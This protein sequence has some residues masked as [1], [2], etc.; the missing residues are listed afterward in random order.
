MG[1]EDCY[2]PL[3]DP[4]PP[5]PTLGTPGW[6]HQDTGPE[7]AAGKPTGLWAADPPSSPSWTCP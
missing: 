3:P 1:L 7:A 5:H 2:T 4:H 6:G